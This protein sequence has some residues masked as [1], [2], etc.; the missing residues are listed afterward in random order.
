MAQSNILKEF[1][2]AIGF[3]IDDHEYRNF[4]SRIDSVTRNMEQLGKIAAAAGTALAV[5]ITKTAS[6]ME[7]LYFASER[8]GTSVGNLMS[9]R[10]AAEQIGVGAEN[11]GAM[12]EHMAS[13]I[14]SNP[15]MQSFFQMVGATFT[16]DSTQNFVNLITKLKELDAGGNGLFARIVGQQFGFDEPT[17]QLLFKELPDLLQQQKEFAALAERGGVNLNAA[18][19]QFHQFMED[20]RK[21]LASVEILGIAFGAKLLPFADRVVQFLQSAVELMLKL[22]DETGGWSS[23][24]GGIV[25]T[26]GGIVASMKLL[27][28]ILGMF[29][30]AGAVAAEAGGAAAAGGLSLGPIIAVVVAG[31]AAYMAIHSETAKKAGDAIGPMI[32]KFEGFSNRIYNDIGGKATIGFGHLVRAGE[33]FSGGI[34]REGASKLL[35]GDMQSAKDSVLRLVKVA[36]NSNQLGALTDFVYNLGSGALAK[37]TLLKKL[38]AG[39]YSGAAEQFSRFNKVLIGGGYQTSAGLTSRRLAEERLFQK[40]ETNLTQQTTIHIHGTDSPAEA[41]RAVAEQQTR[42]NGDLLRNF[43]GVTQ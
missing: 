4:T 12:I 9:I 17:L 18:G 3:D 33:N 35:M 28:G 30:G 1:L 43:V 26:I 8:A 22:N 36:L 13:L 29:G 39:D 5:A 37:S 21:L 10:F 19:P 6:E 40:P 23:A 11:A 31:V 16:S 32:E 2:V 14:R 38:N 7:K 34:S 42:V 15:G 25:V 27:G 41:A 20:V 24:I